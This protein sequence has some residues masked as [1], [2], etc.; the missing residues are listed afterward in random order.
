MGCIRKQRSLFRNMQDKCPNCN[1]NHSSFDIRCSKTTEAAQA[2]RQSRIIGLT[3]WMTLSE[4]IVGPRET[5]KGA[6]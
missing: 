4:L 3:V 1:G 2:A 6:S 5:D